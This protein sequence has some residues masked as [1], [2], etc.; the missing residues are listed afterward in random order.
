[1]ATIE[2]RERVANRLSYAADDGTENPLGTLKY[3]L[4]TGV[5][6]TYRDVFRALEGL[7]KPG[8]CAWAPGADGIYHTRRG[9]KHE[10][11]H[12]G[13]EEN[14]HRCCPYCGALVV[15]RGWEDW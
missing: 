5:S 11:I 4:G 10:F 8:T 1:M 14:G 3:I 6:D 12:A 9:E 15:E 7:V 13:P 2:E